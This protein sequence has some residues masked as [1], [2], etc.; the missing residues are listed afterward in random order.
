MN[1]KPKAPRPLSRTLAGGEGTL[2]SLE[3]RAAALR[4][5]ESVLDRELPAEAQGHWGLARVDHHAMV[6]VADSSAWASRLRYLAQ[7]LV[8]AVENAGG[9]RAGHVTVK[10]GSPKPVEK[11]K[12]PRQLSERARHHL[13]AAASTEDNT[14]LRA[15]LE[16]LARRQRS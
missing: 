8:K 6:L 11:T 3:R 10:V 16:K 13:L 15:A 7:A 9:P 14:A 5:W 2:S 12:T 4:Y 1:D